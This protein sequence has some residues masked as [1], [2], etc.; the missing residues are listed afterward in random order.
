MM[1][2]LFAKDKSE[3]AA[4]YHR[5]MS[6]GAFAAAERIAFQINEPGKPY[7]YPCRQQSGN[8]ANG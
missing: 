6:V 7:A 2:G 4:L 3:L 5:A 1:H 8:Q